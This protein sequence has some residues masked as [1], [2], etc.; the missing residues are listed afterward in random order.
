MRKMIAVLLA[1]VL[2]FSCLFVSASAT[3]ISSPG[4]NA[5]LM[6]AAFRF[7]DSITLYSDDFPPGS[8]D[9][10]VVI[11]GQYDLQGD[12][13]ISIDVKNCTYRGGVNC[14]EHD[15]TVTAYKSTGTNGYI[16]WKLT[17]TL[18]FSWQDPQLG[19]TYEKVYLESPL[20]AFYGLDYVA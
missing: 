2:S 4:V 18:T 15:M 20:Y 3:E 17:G 19:F 5:R 11:S 13:V 16:L 9:F 10:D 7:T 8:A 6:P 12:N 14:S 1:F